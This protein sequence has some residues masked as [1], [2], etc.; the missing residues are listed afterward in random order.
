MMMMMLETPLRLKSKCNHS[1]WCES[2]EGTTID[3]QQEHQF[4]LTCSFQL[5]V[6]TFCCT[7]SDVIFIVQ[8]RNMTKTEIKFDTLASGVSCRSTYCEHQINYVITSY[9]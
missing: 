2:G 6:I 3:R 4:A 8:F 1:A 7:G 5:I 9:E